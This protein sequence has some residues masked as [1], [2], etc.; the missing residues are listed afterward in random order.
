MKHELGAAIVK[1]GE[2]RARG[3]NNLKKARSVSAKRART[4]FGLRTVKNVTKSPSLLLVL[5]F[6]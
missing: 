5:G 3:E 2:D 4:R 1:K 6:S